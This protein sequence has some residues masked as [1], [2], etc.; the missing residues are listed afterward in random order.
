MC[1]FDYEQRDTV[2]TQNRIPLIGPYKEAGISKQDR[3]IQDDLFFSLANLN[4]RRLKI[5]PV[6]S[7]TSNE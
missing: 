4:M 1:E 3:V 2:I 5:C 7:F 6:Q